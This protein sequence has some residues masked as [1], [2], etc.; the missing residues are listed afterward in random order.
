MN[1]WWKIRKVDHLISGGRGLIPGN[2]FLKGNGFFSDLAKG[3][4]LFSI[5]ENL[6]QLGGNV[7]VTSVIGKGTKIVL[8][9]PL[10]NV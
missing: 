2:Y 6:G 5:D 3:F 8:T 4:G 1:D 9:S 7:E 10:K